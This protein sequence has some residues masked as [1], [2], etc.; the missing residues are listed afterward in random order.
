MLF[1][2]F[3]LIGPHKQRVITHKF[4]KGN[5]EKKPTFLVQFINDIFCLYIYIF[6]VVFED[7]ACIMHSP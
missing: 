4:G 7:L 6:F 1:I 2:L 5:I 3:I